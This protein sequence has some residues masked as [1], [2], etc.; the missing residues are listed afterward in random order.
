MHEG[1]RIGSDLVDRTAIG[2][3]QDGNLSRRFQ[4]PSVMGSVT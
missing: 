2:V 1:C 4:Q 3:A